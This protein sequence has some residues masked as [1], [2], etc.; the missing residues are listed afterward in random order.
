MKNKNDREIIKAVLSKVKAELDPARK[1]W[2]NTLFHF[3]DVHNAVQILEDNCLLSRNEAKKREKM[4]SDNASPTIIDQTNE[5][6]KDYV[7][8][9]FR[10]KTPTQYHN[11]GFRPQHQK[12]L[13]GAHCP[14]P[15]FFLFDLESMLFMKNSFFSH[16]SLASPYYTIYNTADKFEEMPF[17]YIYHEGQFNRNTEW[18][19]TGHRQ[20]ELVVPN[21]CS[22]EYLKRIVCRSPAE[23]DT[24]I[25]LLS[26]ETFQ[27]YADKI[28][29]DTR[30]NL[31]YS[32]WF[33]IEKV[34]LMDKSISLT[35][36]EGFKVRGTFKVYL[37]I[38]K[39]DSGDKSFWED[40]EFDQKSSLR[41]NLSTFDKPTDYRV[42][43]YIDDQLAFS[44]GH[45]TI[46][47]L[48]F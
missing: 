17:D 15:I 42:K 25:D 18:F 47:D 22:L 40:K 9:Y 31:F 45:Y 7:R 4:T 28:V 35:F 10:P 41:I 19:I 14:V 38:E 5:V 1:W 46:E 32:E 6:W 20:A 43:F 36:N 44:S 13:N 11:E 39:L 48:P 33:Y 37:D 27:K 26:Y 8:F 34:N 29:V 2:T 24:L 16:G 3:T 12:T 21:K 30:L 23:R